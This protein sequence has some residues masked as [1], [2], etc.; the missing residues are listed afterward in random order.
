[1]NKHQHRRHGVTRAFLVVVVAALAALAAMTSQAVAAPATNSE[2]VSLSSGTQHIASTDITGLE[3]TTGTAL[4][5]HVEAYAKWHATVTTNV[6]W[7]SDHVRQGASLDVARNA[8]VTSGSVA[9]L[10]TITGTL[11]PF[12]NSVGSID[13]GTVTVTKPIPCT[14]ALSGGG[15]Q[16]DATTDALP[17]YPELPGQPYVKLGFDVWF[18]VT[19]EG[20]VVT[21]NLSVGGTKV[22][23]PATLGLGAGLQMAYGFAAEHDRLRPRT[24]TVER[25]LLDAR[26]HVGSRGRGAAELEHPAQHVRG[27]VTEQVFVPDLQVRTDGLRRPRA[28]DEVAPGAR[29][30]G[31]RARR[32][33]R[34][35]PALSRRNQRRRDIAAVAHDVQETSRRE[36]LR[37]HADMQAVQRCL[38][39]H[40]A[41]AGLERENL[42]EDLPH[43]PFHQR[44][45]L[46]LG[47]HRRQ[48]D[49]AAPGP[50]VDPAPQCPGPALVE[51]RDVVREQGRLLRTD[52]AR[53]G[54]DERLQP[55][56][57]TA[58]RADERDELYRP[59]VARLVGHRVRIRRPR[60]R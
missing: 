57:P 52:D 19:P 35:A 43:E 12:G 58:R 18:D 31:D 33:P 24:L 20:V 26:A 7:N 37:D 29:G 40:D 60:C 48:T 59:R 13:I 6:G 9:M 44:C 22:A 11:G 5:L 30:L 16:C 2:S 32:A 15:Y 17:L 54:R 4:N 25:E 46:G 14:L 3:P 42:V 41:G 45:E 47:Q 55:R 38:L 51:L 27:V 49:E 53:V 36:V 10:W 23:G 8:P 56:G 1:M 34:R 50:L 21:R 28:L 39:H